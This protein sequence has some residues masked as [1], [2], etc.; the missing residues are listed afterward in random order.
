M[1]TTEC[2]GAGFVA[3][4]AADKVVDALDPDHKMSVVGDEALKGGVAGT[5]SAAILGIA[6]YRIRKHGRYP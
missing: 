2:I 5:M 4:F 6:A 1:P 3:E